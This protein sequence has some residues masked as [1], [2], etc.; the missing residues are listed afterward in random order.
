M[1]PGTLHA[2]HHDDDQQ[3]D[4]SAASMNDDASC[5]DESEKIIRSLQAIP[6]YEGLDMKT[7][8][9]ISIAKRDLNGIHAAL[10]QPHAS[11]NSSGG[12]PLYIAAYTGYYVGAQVLLS[13]APN[14]AVPTSDLVI[15][16]K[17][18]GHEDIADLML[19]HM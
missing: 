18:R 12:Y 2:Q 17:A 8:L 7:M 3:N 5:I 14:P 4:E 11:A 16:A 13:H 19:Q 15:V 10:Q 6:T 9:L 1:N